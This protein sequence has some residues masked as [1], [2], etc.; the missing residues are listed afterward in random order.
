MKSIMAK[1]ARSK[2]GKVQDELKG[3]GK[4]GKN[5]KAAK[6]DAKTKGKDDDLPSSEEE[7]EPDT[8]EIDRMEQLE[9]VKNALR[10]TRKILENIDENGSMYAQFYDIFLRFCGK[11]T[12]DLDDDD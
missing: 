11:L 3:E 6:G 4:G 5:K 8:E 7:P 2:G 10:E 1:S 9:L 12:D